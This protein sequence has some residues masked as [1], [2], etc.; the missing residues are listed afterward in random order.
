MNK[1]VVSKMMCG[2]CHMQVC[3]EADATDKEILEV[4]NG[5]NPS[6]TSKGW[7]KVIRE[8][9][10]PDEFWPIEKLK[11]VKCDDNDGRK[12]FMVAC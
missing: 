8:N 10:E 4:C 5:E 12:H 9:E 3:A 2:I 7:C 1:V 6:G 11:P